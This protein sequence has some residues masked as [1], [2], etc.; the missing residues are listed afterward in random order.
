MNQKKGILSDYFSIDC[1]GLTNFSGNVEPR[2]T[3]NKVFFLTKIPTL[4][5]EEI[6]LFKV[7]ISKRRLW[8]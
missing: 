7:K 5:I 6:N 1:T 2:K 8:A 3:N 4:V